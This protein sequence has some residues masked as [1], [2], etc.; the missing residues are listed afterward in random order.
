MKTELCCYC[1]VGYQSV[2][3]FVDLVTCMAVYRDANLI[4]NLIFLTKNL[5]SKAIP[6]TSTSFTFTSF[7]LILP[8]LRV[9][10]VNEV[11]FL[12]AHR[13]LR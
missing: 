13:L 8:V 5:S 6:S 3:T 10:V 2:D 11:S 9:D 1:S 7:L 12:G 4:F